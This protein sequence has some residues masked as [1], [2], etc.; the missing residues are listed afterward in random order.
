MSTWRI[1]G[2]YEWSEERRYI[3]VAY[4]DT[5]V[6]ADTEDAAIEKAIAER[7]YEA[8]DEECDYTDRSEWKRGDRHG[9]KAVLTDTDDEWLRQQTENSINLAYMQRHSAPLFAEYV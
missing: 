6:D 9:L 4:I 1:T 3:C 2:Q 8:D 5:S 7:N